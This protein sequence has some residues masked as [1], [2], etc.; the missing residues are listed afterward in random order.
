MSSFP[1]NRKLFLTGTGGAFLALPQLE[2]YVQGGQVPKRMVA[3][4]TFYGLMPDHFFP[5]E[6]GKEYKIPELLK[7]LAHHRKDFT[8]FSGLDHNLSGGHEIT[9]YFLTGIKLEDSKSRPEANISVDQK[10]AQFVGAK[11][12]FPSIALS[13][14]SGS[15][16]HISWNRN[17]AQVETVKLLSEFKDLL[18]NNPTKKNLKRKESAFEEQNSILDLVRNQAKKFEANLGHTDRDKLDQYFTSVRELELKMDQSKEWLYKP[19]P[20]STY[21]L[22]NGADSFPLVKKLPLFY[23]LMTLALQ[24]DSTRVLTLSQYHVGGNY[25]G[26]PGVAGDYHA[27][28]HHG[29]VASSIQELMKI[30]KFFT[31]QFSRFIDKLKSVKEPNGGTLLDNTMCLLGSGMSNG[32][33]HSNR[34]LPILLAGGGFS[35]GE[36]KIYEKVNKESVSL[37]NLFLTMLQKFGL[38]IDEFNN[39]TS[40]LSNFS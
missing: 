27:L 37:N 29:R 23:D 7:P 22:P 5:K 3:S 39:S 25:G 17:G 4:A 11:T 32:N 6:A 20:E 16:N 13:C 40:T 35:H 36:H 34:N 10:A 9:K 19:K 2:A 8:V 15:A 28:S 26:I 1:L 14:L 30:E 18:F 38:E 33:S 24:T 31:S 21:N 12:R